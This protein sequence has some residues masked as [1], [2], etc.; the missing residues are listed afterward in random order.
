MRRSA[1]RPETGDFLFCLMESK[2]SHN[3]VNAALTYIGLPYNIIAYNKSLVP[4]NNQQVG[5]DVFT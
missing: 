3:F 5:T 2:Y 4:N 1:Q